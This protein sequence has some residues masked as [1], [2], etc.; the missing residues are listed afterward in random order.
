MFSGGVER[1][2]WHEIALLSFLRGNK[3]IKWSKFFKVQSS[4]L[5]KYATE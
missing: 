3:S 1:D 4:K 5:V 2:Q